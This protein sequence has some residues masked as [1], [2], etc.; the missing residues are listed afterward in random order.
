VGAWRNAAGHPL[1][2]T[3]A[4]PLTVTVASCQHN[5]GP[6]GN[7]FPSFNFP[8]LGVGRSAFPDDNTGNGSGN[9]AEG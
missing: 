8:H 1:K 4:H 3:P 6:A 5:P 7:L 2:T 9:Q